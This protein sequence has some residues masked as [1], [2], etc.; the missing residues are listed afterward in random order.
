MSEKYGRKNIIVFGLFLLSV[1]T[2][3]QV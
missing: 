1:I 3:L 2:L